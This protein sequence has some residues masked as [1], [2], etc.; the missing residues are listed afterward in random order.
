MMARST[1]RAVIEMTYPTPRVVDVR[2]PSLEASIQELLSLYK[3]PGMLDGERFLAELED[4]CGV[5]RRD[6]AEVRIFMNWAE[7]AEMVRGGMSVGSH[8]HSHE[9]L[10]RLPFEKQCEELRVSR[11]ILWRQLG[12]RVRTLAYPVGS[13]SSFS[14]TTS[15]ALEAEGYDAAFSFYGGVNLPGRIQPHN[16]LR[17]GVELDVSLPRLGLSLLAASVTGRDFLSG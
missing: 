11:D 5:A 4:A 10:A 8:T 17:M 9:L 14:E 16:V 6:E 12:V 7:A 3:S 2:E 15:R 1:T 13:R